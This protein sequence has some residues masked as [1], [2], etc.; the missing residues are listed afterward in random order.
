MR[1]ASGA[2]LERQAV[3]VDPLFGLTEEQR[4]FFGMH[5]E[6]DIKHSDLGWK[7]VAKHATNL[8]MEDE[9]VDACEENLIVWDH[10]L[11]GIAD[12]GDALDKKMGWSQKVK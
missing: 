3:A 11:N 6:A 2:D 5:S 9:V 12:A 4:L 10:Y 1:H 7:T 8:H